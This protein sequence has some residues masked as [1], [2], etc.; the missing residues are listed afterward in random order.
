MAGKKSEKGS[1]VSISGGNCCGHDHQRGYE[2]G[3]LQ[4]GRPDGSA[5]LAPRRRLAGEQAK[6]GSI[7]DPDDEAGHQVRQAALRRPRLKRLRAGIENF[8]QGSLHRFI[9]L[10]KLKDCIPGPQGAGASLLF[11]NAQ[12]A[13]QSEERA[14]QGMALKQGVG[15]ALALPADVVSP[16]RIVT[17]FFDFPANGCVADFHDEREDARSEGQPGRKARRSGKVSQAGEQQHAEAGQKQRHKEDVKH[18]AERVV[19]DGEARNSF[20]G[21]CRA[22]THDFLP[23]CLIPAAY[24]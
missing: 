4:A 23:V 6:D 1:A 13:G 22:M 17:A 24:G 16:D 10:S 18:R 21:Q 12:H 20:C 8:C 14:R 2:S 15:L 7:E 3:S 19:N 11:V 5:G 9:P